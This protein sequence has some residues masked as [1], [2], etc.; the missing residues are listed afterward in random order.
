[1][2]LVTIDDYDLDAARDE[3]RLPLSLVTVMKERGGVHGM[4]GD[5]SS[6]RPPSSSREDG[7]GRCASHMTTGREMP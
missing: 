5:V 2:N 7:A 1:M 3:R 6:G 4:G